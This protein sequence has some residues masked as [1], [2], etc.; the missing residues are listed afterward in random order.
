MEDYKDRLPGGMADGK[1]PTD[2][3][4]ETLVK[5]IET[6][7][8][9]TSDAKLAREIAM[10][11]LTEDP[12]YYDKLESIEKKYHRVKQDINL[13]KDI[14]MIQDEFKKNGYK[15]YLVGGAVRDSISGIKPKDYD[16]ATDALP[17]E[18]ERI[19]R[20]K[21]KMLPIGEKFGIWLVV[22]P[23][24]EY[25]IATFREDIGQGRRPEAVK[26][27]TIENDVKRRDLTINA[28]FYDIETGEIV[29][30]VGGI[31]D[32]K[33]GVVRAVGDPTDRFNE[34]RLRILRAI[35]FAGITGSELDKSI[36]DSL[37]KDASLEGISNERIRDEF[38]KGLAKS[39]SVVYFM[40]LL[41]KYNLF[42]W[43]FPKLNINGNYIEEKDYILNLATLLKENDSIELSKILNQ[44]TYTRKEI[45]NILF[46][47]SLLY[48]NEDNAY[49]IKKKQGTSDLT[50]DQILKFADYNKLDTSLIKRFLKYQTGVTGK[51]V[52]DKY[53][54]KPGPEMGKYIKQMELDR[55]KEIQESIQLKYIKRFN[56]L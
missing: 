17:D 22:T 24:D 34:D 49:E 20:P 31:N 23:T 38:L 45:A 42:N 51:E 15:L 27:T 11:H 54:V 5:G 50:N 25:E 12:Q 37:T 43:I 2:F 39:S 40:N 13:P 35:R 8:E 41:D 6:E 3:P 14:L 53:Q 10:D 4:K 36:H 16:L 9:H 21:Y 48:L 30:L 47:L 44:Q 56:E 32:L 33:T 7:M 55:F 46:L 18:V 28:L 52:I 29:D 26:F 19:L 1:K